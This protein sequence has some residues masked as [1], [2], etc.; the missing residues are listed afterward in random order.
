MSRWGA[1]LRVAACVAALVCV[2][3]CGERASSQ[4]QLADKLLDSANDDDVEI[5]E[6]CVRQIA[7]QFTDEDAEQM[8]DNID[9]LDEAEVSPEGEQLMFQMLEC[10]SFTELDGSSVDPATLDA[11]AVEQMIDEYVANIPDNVDPDCFRQILNGVD[12]AQLASGQAPELFSGITACLR[13]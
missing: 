7:V 13:G 2:S 5:D 4:D 8:V 9:S 1:V 10:A 3:A 12:P 11:A 6:A